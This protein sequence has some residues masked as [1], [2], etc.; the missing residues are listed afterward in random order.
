MRAEIRLA[1]RLGISPRRLW[2]EPPA[3]RLVPDGE[4]G[5][6]V[7]REREFTHEDIELL[8][9][10]RLAEEQL[11]PRGIEWADELDPH[12]RFHVGDEKGLPSRN[13][14]LAA[15]EKAKQAYE[16]Q[17]PD[18]DTASLVWPVRLV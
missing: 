10:A 2:G 9:A 14:A 12:S 18:A 15:I 1:E 8:E 6:H 16:K 13:Y 4:G 17:W 7:V 3:E 5:F 11:S